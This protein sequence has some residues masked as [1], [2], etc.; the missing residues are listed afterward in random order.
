V[1]GK[2]ANIE[3]SNNTPANSTAPR[4]YR[5][6][7]SDIDGTLLDSTSTLRPTVVAAVRAAREAGIIFTLATGRRYSTTERILHALG[8]LDD[9]GGSESDDN[10]RALPDHVLAP[11]VVL[12]GGAVVVSTD[13]SEVLFRNP[14]ARES[15]LKCAAILAEM[16]LQPILYDDEVSRQGLR[17]GPE[18]FDNPPTRRYLANHPHVVQ[19]QPYSE[20][21]LER[22]PL[23]LAVIGPLPALQEAATRLIL[24][25]SRVIT[26]HSPTLDSYFMEVFHEECS[27]ASASEYVAELLG[28][29]M[30]ETVCIGDNWNDLEML[31]HAGCG[32]AVGN[33]DPGVL[34]V[35]R[36]VTVSNDE[37]AVA[38]V[39]GQ[40]IAGIEPGIPNPLYEP[41]THTT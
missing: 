33:A 35:A 31:T 26:S 20:W 39:L 21:T 16:G 32:V 6:V 4:R 7:L 9:A 17:T 10:N 12:N 8:L 29:T 11:P 14:L 15:A 40:I 38:V 1:N 23:Q 19:R 5:L 2:A 18:H 13:A 41:Q 30:A 34:P 24:A 3:P 25:G 37:D 36:R 28:L 22:D 27:K